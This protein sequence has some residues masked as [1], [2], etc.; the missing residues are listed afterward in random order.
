MQAGLVYDL[1]V[2][3]P[4][5]SDSRDQDAYEPLACWSSKQTG[6]HAQEIRCTHATRSHNFIS[7]Y[8]KLA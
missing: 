6:G 8:M 5:A 4:V 1:F 3:I 2:F 7:L